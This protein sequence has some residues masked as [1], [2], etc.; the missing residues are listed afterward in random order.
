MIM[1]YYMTRVLLYLFNNMMEA[2]GLNQ[3]FL[4]SYMKFA[5]FFFTEFM[6]G[7]VFYYQLISIIVTKF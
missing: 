2:K 4:S 1:L 6:F 7:A 5:K 3:N